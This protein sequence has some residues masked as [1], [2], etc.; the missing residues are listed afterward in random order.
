MEAAK[1]E[2]GTEHGGRHSEAGLVARILGWASCLLPISE[3][4]T[5]FARS[6]AAMSCALFAATF[7]AV[8]FDLVATLR[9]G[10][11]RCASANG[12]THTASKR[13]T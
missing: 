4:G 13:S 5:D 11:F 6:R 10:V 9:L 7:V 8:T 2:A 1:R 3:L 12:I